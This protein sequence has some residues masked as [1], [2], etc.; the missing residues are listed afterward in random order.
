MQTSGVEL[1]QY[2]GLIQFASAQRVVG[3]PSGDMTIEQQMPYVLKYFKSVASSLG[4]TT[5]PLLSHSLGE[6]THINRVR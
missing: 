4:S 5:K 1:Q 6:R 3:L 2:R